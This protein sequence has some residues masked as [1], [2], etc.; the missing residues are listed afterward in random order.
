ME[1]LKSGSLFD[2]VDSNQRGVQ[3]TKE[4]GRND[5][6][7]CGSGKKYKA[8]CIDAP[9]N[10][11][12]KH[13]PTRNYNW[14]QGEIRGIPT[15]K[16][17]EKL[18]MCGIIFQTDEFLNDV[19]QCLGA[20]DI[21]ERW[22]TRCKF[23][24][25]GFD[26]D[27]PWMAAEVLW[28]RLAPNKVSTEQIDDWMQDGYDLIRNRDEE[29]GCTLWLKV[30]QEL[31]PRFTK[32]MRTIED[33]EAVFQG[34]Q[35]LFNWCQDMEQELGNAAVDDMSFH[36]HRIH[37]C[38]EFCGFF[39]DSQTI[40]PNMRRAIA[41]SLFMSGRRD[42]GERE[43]LSLVADY[44]DDPWGYISWGDMYSGDFGIP[45]NRSRA[46]ELYRKALGIDPE[47]DKTILER[48]ADLK[49]VAHR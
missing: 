24:A 2:A 22:K 15:H 28:K 23:T 42:E 7:P 44:P 16:I 31:K 12:P 25:Q 19:E 41:E 34:M 30:W 4:I 46:E 5:P 21:Y 47:E 29:G 26:E 14:N 48:I 33:A 10:L 39:P 6:C 45:I 49:E 17:I 11:F 1:S 36:D 18:E 37:Y 9:M 20:K 40:V 38:R 3:V 35:C 43:Y 8:C 32:S 27:F 13:S